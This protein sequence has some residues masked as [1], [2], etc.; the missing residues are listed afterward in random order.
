MVDFNPCL[1]FR[2]SARNK[3]YLDVIEDALELIQS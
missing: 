1:F 3:S 2:R